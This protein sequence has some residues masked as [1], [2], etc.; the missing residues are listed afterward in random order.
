M[1]GIFIDWVCG[2]AHRK[3][4]GPWCLPGSGVANGE[5][6]SQGIRIDHPELFL[7]LHVRAGVTEGCLSSEVCSL[8]DERIP[9]PMPD[10]LALP[11]SRHVKVAARI[12][13]HRT[14][15]MHHL[16]M[17]ENEVICLN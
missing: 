15:V 7:Q 6:I 8:N 4:R 1:T 17:N 5:F 13:F 9:L 14:D 2:S 12:H 11:F 10:G 16:V 3:H